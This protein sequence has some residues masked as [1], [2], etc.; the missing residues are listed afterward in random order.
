MSKALS[1]VEETFK[2]QLAPILNLVVRLLKNSPHDASHQ[3]SQG[4]NKGNSSGLGSV[5]KRVQPDGKIFPKN[6]LIPN[7]L[8]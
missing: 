1:F 5:V 6:I 8:V 7:A 4:G 2:S 3:L